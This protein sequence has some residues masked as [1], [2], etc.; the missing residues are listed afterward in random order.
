MSDAGRRNALRAFAV[1]AILA[2][3]A[4]FA[5]QSVVSLARPGRHGPLTDPIDFVAFYC[6]GRVLASHRDPYRA[7]PLRTCEK[8]ALLESR[9]TIVPHLVVPAPFPPYALALFGVLSLATFRAACCV[10]FFGSIVAIGFG[11]V[12]L[13]ELGGASLS[14]VAVV[15]TI[16]LGVGSLFI[17]QLVPYVFAALCASALALR[18]GR[19]RLATA[20]ALAT[21]VEPHVGLAV[22]AGLAVLERRART[23]LAIG[24]VAFAAVSLWA[25]GA[26][27]AVEYATR[28]LPAHARSEIDNFHAQYSLT[29][30]LR[31]LGVEP[32]SALRA[33]E[34]WYAAMLACGVALARRLR[35]R[36][37]DP[38]FATLTPAACVLF[39][40]AFVHD[41]QMA[42]ALPFAFLL[43]RYA[44]RRTL[45]TIA[46]VLLAIPWQSVFELFLTPYFPGRGTFAPV[47]ILARVAG[48][49]RLAEDVWRA[50]TLMLSVRDGRTPLEIFA[51]KLPTWF[52]FAVLAIVSLRPHVSRAATPAI[53]TTGVQVASPPLRSAI[54]R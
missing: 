20:C 31:A 30:L 52:A 41:H 32:E 45:V 4:A 22:V 2:V 13:R 15:A 43:S 28:V 5:P 17:G 9:L 29:A 25:G 26:D 11:I 53:V 51:F 34:A 44:R 48:P 16:A 19:V 14:F 40:G 3:L 47:P 35:T 18:C 6:G 38:A 33:G 46:I 49:A 24:L 7:E 21:L 37:A 12:A 42:L 10:F 54:R 8:D 1:V 23:P 27:L 36:Y 50:W 39:G